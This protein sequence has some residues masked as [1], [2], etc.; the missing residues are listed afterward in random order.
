MPAI[1]RSGALSASAFLKAVR[2]GTRYDLLLLRGE[3]EL[4]L[5]Q[6]LHEYVSLAMTPEAASFDYSELRISEVEGPALWNALTTLP[7]LGERRLV[8]LEL[9]GEPKSGALEALRNYLPRAARTT[10]LVMTWMTGKRKEPP[11]VEIP[12]TGVEVTFPLLNERER[13]AWAE[14]YAKT[15]GKSLTEEAVQ[16]LIETS[17]KNLT[18]LA[19]KLDHAILFVGDAKEVTVQV[20]MEVS[21]VSSEFTVFN[22]EDAILEQRPVEA[23]QFARSLLEGG[24][25]LLGL[26]A[27][28]RGTVNRLWHLASSF[29]KPRQW[30]SSPEA[31]QLWDRLF[32][33]KIFKLNAFREAARA[34]GETRIQAAV[35]GLL[36]LELKAKSGQ[37]SPSA[38]F[39]W[40]WRLSSPRPS[41]EEPRSLPTS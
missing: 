22:L 9:N 17:S 6:A 27:L 23:V 20:L 33:R 36:D 19:A 13:A 16:Y 40:L 8:V 7:L 32:S 38:Y 1:A 10:S 34:I 29:R 18:D 31:Q 37:D 30:E 3:E 4:L 24:E 15:R 12:D 5:R 25:R 21:G 41:L 26:L 2:K 14:A 11:P 35:A 39:D 28:H